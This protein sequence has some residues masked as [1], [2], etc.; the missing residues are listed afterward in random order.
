MSTRDVMD[1]KN[2]KTEETKEKERKRAA[3]KEQ[4]RKNM[5][6]KCGKYPGK[7]ACSHPKPTCI[8]CH[9]TTSACLYMYR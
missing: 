3:R 8:E 4:E 1:E 6:C 5:C 9:D 2:K 7:M